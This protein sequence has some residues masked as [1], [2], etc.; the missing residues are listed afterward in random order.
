M[1]PSSRSNNKRSKHKASTPSWSAYSSNVKMGPVSSSEKVCELLLNH[2]A[3]CSK[4]MSFF[5]SYCL[6]NLKSY[7]SLSTFHT[8]I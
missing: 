1:P 6:E 8:V 5:H 4:K 2:T 3:S 7:V